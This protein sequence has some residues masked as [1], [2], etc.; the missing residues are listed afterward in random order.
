MTENEIADIKLFVSA[1]IQQVLDEAFVGMK[2]TDTV[3]AAV[4]NECL[5]VL[6]DLSQ[7]FKTPVLEEI[8]VVVQMDGPVCN[9]TFKA[10]TP[11]ADA[12]LRGVAY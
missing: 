3:R 2:V 11:E 12:F 1:K 8:Q 9:V 4:V 5:T 10:L 7:G 6:K